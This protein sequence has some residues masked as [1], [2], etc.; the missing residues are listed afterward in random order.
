MVSKS[1]RGR[2]LGLFPATLYARLPV[3]KRPSGLG[4]HPPSATGHVVVEVRPCELI[5][6]VQGSPLQGGVVRPRDG[7]AALAQT[8]VVPE[9]IL[10]GPLS[11]LFATFRSGGKR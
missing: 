6:V 9:V 7:M 4:E 10:V 5:G 3:L 8:A 2:T 11:A 1:R